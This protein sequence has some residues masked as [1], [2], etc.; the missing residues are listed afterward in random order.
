VARRRD[1]AVIFVIGLLPNG[2]KRSVANIEMINRTFE[3]QRD[4]MR[5][6]MRSLPVVRGCVDRTG[7]GEDTTET[8]QREF[9]SALLEGV[10]FNIQS[11]EELV[12]SVREGLEKRDFLLQNDSKFHRQIHSIKRIPTSGRA[13]RYDSERDDLGHA[14]G[15]WAWALANYAMPRQGAAKSFYEQYHEKRA[16]SAVA[17]ENPGGDEPVRGKSAHRVL[18]EWGMK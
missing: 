18:R 4:Q 9:S 17:K 15:F 5:K 6:I 14:D 11:K 12:R 13:F 8:L 7:Q 10:E 16:G 3:Y 1:A 2:K